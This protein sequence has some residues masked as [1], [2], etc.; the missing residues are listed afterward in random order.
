MARCR[1]RTTSKARL[2]SARGDSAA[3]AAMDGGNATWM[4]ATLR[5]A[6]AA[7]RSQWSARHCAESARRSVGAAHPASAA[8]QGGGVDE[9]AA[10]ASASRRC[11]DDDGERQ[12]VGAARSVGVAWRARLRR[13]GIDSGAVNGVEQARS[14]VLSTDRSS[15]RVRFDEVRRREDSNEVSL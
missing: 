10:A 14:G 11:D 12:L 1:R 5:T 4:K 6:R 3:V 13:R 15:M 7:R 8:T 9:A 2:R